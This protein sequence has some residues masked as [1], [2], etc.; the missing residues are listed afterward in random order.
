MKENH[1]A[2]ASADG[3]LQI[4]DI[5]HKRL[6]KTHQIDPIEAGTITNMACFEHLVYALTHNSIV[7]CFDFRLVNMNF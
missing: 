4:F 2:I 7:Y 1:L 5:S 6:L 3:E